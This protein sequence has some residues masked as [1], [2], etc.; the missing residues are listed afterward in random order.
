METVE[1]LFDLMKN[2]SNMGIIA[3]VMNCLQP[4]NIDPEFATTSLHVCCMKGKLE[5]VKYLVLKDSHRFD[6][7]N[8]PDERG[9]RPILYAALHDHMDIVQF[10]VKCGADHREIDEKPAL[11]RSRVLAAVQESQ[12]VVDQVRR[13]YAANI[14]KFMKVAIN[15]RNAPI[16]LDVAGLVSEFLTP[17]S[18]I[19]CTDTSLLCEN[20]NLLN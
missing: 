16:G 15:S 6:R 2:A 5:V 11:F 13:Y 18:M 20:R 3:L 9:Y 17:Y 7:V 10:L 12:G 14:N 8:Q 19:E 4:L 1:E